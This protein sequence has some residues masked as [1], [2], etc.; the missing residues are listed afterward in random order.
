MIYKLTFFV[1]QEAKESVKEALFDAGAGRYEKYDRCSWEVLGQGQFRPLERAN[2]YIGTP[3]RLEV[4]AE[5]RVEMIC[6]EAYIK[7]AVLALKR[8]HP[9]EE[10]AYEVIKLESF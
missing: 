6:Q 1:P 7:E 8:A 4:L 2:P 3:N 9:Y 10:V 5:Y